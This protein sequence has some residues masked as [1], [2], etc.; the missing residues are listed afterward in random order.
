MEDNREIMNKK[1]ACEYLGIDEKRLDTL[2]ANRQITYARFGGL[3][4]RR[5][6]LDDFKSS[7]RFTMEEHYCVYTHTTPDG[8]VYVGQSNDINDRWTGD[9]NRYKNKSKQFYDE[10][11]KWGWDDMRHEVIA[12][13]DNRDDALALED[14]MIRFCKENGCSLNKVRSRAFSNSKEYNREY[15]KTHNRKEYYR[16]YRA[17]KKMLSSHDRTTE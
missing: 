14:L 5:K 4:F 1:Q 15:Y 11:V 2:V 16:E 12:T 17:K 7:N 9:G 8:M 3:K 10:T 6:W 13:F